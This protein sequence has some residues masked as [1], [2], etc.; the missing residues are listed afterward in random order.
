MIHSEQKNFLFYRESKF[1][2]PYKNLAGNHE[3]S[4]TIDD[5]HHDF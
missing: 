5:R 4:I 3:N 1:I 2:T